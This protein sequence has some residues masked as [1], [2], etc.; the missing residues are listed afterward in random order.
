MLNEQMLELANTAASMLDGDVL[1]SVTVESAD[2][3]EIKE[4][5]GARNKFKQ[6]N[7]IVYIYVVRTDENNEN[8]FYFTVD[9]DPDDPAAFGEEIVYTDALYFASK[10]TPA[11][12]RDASE[13]RWGG[14]YSTFSPVYDSKGGI[15]GILCHPAR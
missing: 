11:I 3:P 9:P 1:G 15:G 4:I 8:R 13:D 14:F 7:N 2:S 10:G 5:V 12:D 6:H